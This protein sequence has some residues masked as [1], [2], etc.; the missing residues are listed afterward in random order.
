MNTTGQRIPFLPG[1]PGTIAARLPE[2][3][4]MHACGIAGRAISLGSRARRVV[5]A[6]LRQIHDTERCLS[7]TQAARISENR[8]PVQARVQ[9][10][11]T[12]SN[13]RGKRITASDI[14]ASYGRYW[15]ELLLPARPGGATDTEQ[16]DVQGLAHLEA[17]EKA[18]PVCAVT[19]HLGNWDLAARWFA[20][21]LPGFAVM[22]EELANGRLFEAFVRLRERHGMRV[23]HGRSS[24]TALYRHLRRGGHA[25]LVVDRAFGHGV[26]AVP[27][28]G[29][30]RLFPSSGMRIARRA[31]A[32]LLPVFLVRAR[33]RFCLRIHPAI[34]P[35]SDPVAGF[36]G[37]LES[38]ILAFPEQW[39]VLYPLHDAVGEA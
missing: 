38:E 34:G 30:H 20:R 26:E 36:A 2:R 1:T 9:V 19:G 27:F 37:V 14:Y 10:G 24:G 25:G 17:A 35:G 32:S 5:A 16:F 4:V 3:L 8:R 22:A 39:C 23:I 18:G 12:S 33:G 29:G 11:R 31:G 15:A 21:R 13:G 28:L 6:N 7:Q